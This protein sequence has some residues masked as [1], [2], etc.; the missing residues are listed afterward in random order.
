VVFG[1]MVLAAEGDR[2]VARPE[3]PVQKIRISA[4]PSAETWAKVRATLSQLDEFEKC[5]IGL[6]V[7]SSDKVIALLTKVLTK[8]FKVKLPT[9]LVP[10]LELPASVS[11]SVEVEDQQVEL[12]VRPLHLRVEPRALWYSASVDAQVARR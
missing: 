7:L 12:V 11:E 10:T 8:G 5:G 9:K 6:E 4:E 2:I 1:D 3:F